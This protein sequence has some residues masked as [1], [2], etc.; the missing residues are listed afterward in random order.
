MKLNIA[1]KLSLA[2]ILAV[3]ALVLLLQSDDPMM[4]LGALAVF[5]AAA[6]TD[7]F[8]GM[9]AR[10]LGISTTFGKFLDP[11]ADKILVCSTLVMLVHLDRVPAW[12]VILILAREFMVTGLRAV[13]ADEGIVLAADKLGK[14]KTALQ[15]TAIAL[16]IVWHPLGGFDPVPSGIALFY[17]AVIITV[18][19]GWNYLRSF[20]G[21]QGKRDVIED[22]SE[23]SRIIH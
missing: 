6:A 12:A 8:D 20:F 16:L 2:R 22:D 3:P 1:D 17:L 9:M 4:N 21:A 23:A 18:Y 19:S 10:K 5:I 14:L 11:L 15:L 7:F 13:A